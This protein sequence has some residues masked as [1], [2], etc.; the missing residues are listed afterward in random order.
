LIWNSPLASFPSVLISSW[1][2]FFDPHPFR[3]KNLTTSLCS[4]FSIYCHK[5]IS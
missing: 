1:W 4:Y 2:I 3:Q 5:R